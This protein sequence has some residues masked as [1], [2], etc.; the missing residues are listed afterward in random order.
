MNSIKNYFNDCDQKLDSIKFVKQRMDILD[1]D[2]ENINSSKEYE[3]NVN[4]YIN[5]RSV[6]EARKERYYTECKIHNYF[7]KM[8]NKNTI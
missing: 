4:E 5:S 8:L 6:Y 7:N 2:I 1:K 3:H